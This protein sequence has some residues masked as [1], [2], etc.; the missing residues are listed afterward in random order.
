MQPA[1]KVKWRSN[2]IGP[3]ESAN[4]PPDASARK[5]PITLKQ[6]KLEWATRAG[7]MTYGVTMQGPG[8]SKIARVRMAGLERSGDLK[9]A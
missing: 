7:D 1:A 6:K 9:R 5:N 2:P 3:P 4:A 8:V